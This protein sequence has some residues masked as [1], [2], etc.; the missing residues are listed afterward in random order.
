MDIF[1]DFFL[2]NFKLSYEICILTSFFNSEYQ[3]FY[4]SIYKYI[5]MEISVFF[6]RLMHILYFSLKYMREFGVYIYIC[7][8][9]Y[10]VIYNNYYLLFLENN[11]FEN[12][13]I[14]FFYVFSK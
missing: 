1:G 5:A 10:L 4:L 12:I 14:Y 11:N 9:F 13:Y 3:S 8:L 6:K 2:Y 7:C